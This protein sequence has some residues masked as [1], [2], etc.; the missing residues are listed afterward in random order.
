MWALRAL[1]FQVKNIDGAGRIVIDR[2]TGNIENMIKELKGRNWDS[3]DLL[4]HT[5]EQEFFKTKYSPYLPKELQKEMYIAH[6]IDIDEMKK[7]LKTY[8][9]RIINSE[10]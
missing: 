3:K 1:G 4:E 10:H 7:Y 2:V 9:F 8:S 5:L 6:E